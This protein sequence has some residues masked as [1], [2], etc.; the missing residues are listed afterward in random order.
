MRSAAATSSHIYS[1]LLALLHVEDQGALG[2]FSYLP[3]FVEQKRML[4]VDTSNTAGPC[5]Q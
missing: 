1:Q 3:P 5:K 4:G 2:V